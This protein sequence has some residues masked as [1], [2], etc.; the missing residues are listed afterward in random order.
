MSQL[1]KIAETHLNA[2]K[3]ALTD[4]LNEIREQEYSTVAEVVG[5]IELDLKMI[6]SLEYEN[7]AKL[8]NF[9]GSQFDG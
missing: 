5:V 2:K 9:T 8:D 4:L 6:A 3:Q 7:E 1:S